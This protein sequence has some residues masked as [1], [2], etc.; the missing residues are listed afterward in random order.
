M[1]VPEFHETRALGV[2]HHA[3]LERYGAKL[4]GLSAAWPHA[5]LLVAADGRDESL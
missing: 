3:A 5:G 1:S 4:V 2:F